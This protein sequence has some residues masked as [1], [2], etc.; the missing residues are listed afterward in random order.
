MEVIQT[1][2]KGVVIIEPRLFKDDRGYFFESY[3]ERDF[4]KQVGEVH[5]V[6]D[7]ESKSSYGVMRGL[8]FQRPPFTQSKLVR[9]VKGAVLDVAVDIR[10]GS[11]TYGQHVAVELTE[12]NHRQFFIPRGFAHGFAVLSPEAIF[13]YKCDNFYHPEADGG[14]SILDTSL[15]IDWRIPTEHAIL[16]EKDTKHPL[17]KDFDSPFEFGPF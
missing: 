14:I 16:S 11:P 10:K 15:G 9:C 13:Q 5:F 6:Q 3:S 1:N 4:N 17:L 7:N 12:D 8:H 2:I